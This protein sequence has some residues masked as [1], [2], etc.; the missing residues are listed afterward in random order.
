MKVRRC[1]AYVLFFVSIITLSVPVFPHH[2][3]ADGM[4]CMKDADTTGC[5]QQ[6]NTMH[7]DCCCNTGCVTTHFFQKAHT[8][9]NTGMQPAP[10]GI[11]FLLPAA[12]LK[13]ALPLED[14]SIL[15]KYIYIETLHGT[16]TARAI[17]LRAPPTPLY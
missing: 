6:H 12:A 13:P 4:L 1:I 11:I 5:S 10:S 16:Y 3:H 17:G 2:H 9:S 8:T 15:Y 7:S 14:K